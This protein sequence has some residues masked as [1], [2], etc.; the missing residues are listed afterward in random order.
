[1]ELNFKVIDQQIYWYSKRRQYKLVSKTR[2]VEQDP[3][4]GYFEHQAE[5][6]RFRMWSNANEYQSEQAL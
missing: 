2:S 6:L 5:Q 1:M 3:D 4:M